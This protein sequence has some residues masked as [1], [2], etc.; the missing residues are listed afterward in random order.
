[1]CV[2]VC[3][4]G[5][6]INVRSSPQLFHL[7]LLDQM[8]NAQKGKKKKKDAPV[9]V[10]FALILGTTKLEQSVLLAVTLY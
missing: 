7:F 1:M 2:C 3:R 8:L 9:Y 5:V 6:F 4:G 10:T